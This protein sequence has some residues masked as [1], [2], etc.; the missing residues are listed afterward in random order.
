MRFETRFEASL[1]YASFKGFKIEWAIRFQDQINSQ[2]STTTGRLLAKSTISSVLAANKGFIFWLADQPG[3]KS[4][5]RPSD[6]DYFDMSAKGARI[7]H[8]VRE[9]PYPSME[10]ARHAFNFMPENTDTDKRNKAIFAFL[11]L[12]GA[13]DGAMLSLRLTYINFTDRC[14][15]HDAREVRAKNSKTITAHLLSVDDA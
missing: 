2:V 8:T 13:R 11:M 12:T 1:K 9:T 4:R 6:A 15:Y 7:A 10:Q 14:V 3:Y 5:I